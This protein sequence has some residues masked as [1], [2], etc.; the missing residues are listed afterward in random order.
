[1]CDVLYFKRKHVL[2]LC[3]LVELINLVTSNELQGS[4]D[5]REQHKNTLYIVLYWCV[6]NK[7]LIVTVIADGKASRKGGQLNVMLLY[8]VMDTDLS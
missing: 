4:I 8:L 3:I 7:C 5:R 1:M 6:L 2:C